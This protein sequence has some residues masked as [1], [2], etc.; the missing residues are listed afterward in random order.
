MEKIEQ[1]IKIEKSAEELKREKEE[2][3]GKMEKI[4]EMFGTEKAKERFKNLLDAY[5]EILRGVKI[6]SKTEAQSYEGE[7][8]EIHKKIMDTLGALSIHQKPGGEEE[9]ILRSL[10]DKDIAAQAIDDYYAVK[11][12]KEHPKLTEFGKLYHELKEENN[13]NS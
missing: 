7:R 6:K 10:A 1:K 5:Y 9:K 13:Q 4:L 3:Y 8:G 2:N 11:F 12:E